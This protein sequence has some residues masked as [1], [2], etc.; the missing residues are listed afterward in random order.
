MRSMRVGPA[1]FIEQYK[2]YNAM[3]VLEADNSISWCAIIV[4][5]TNSF[6]FHFLS[7]VF[8]LS[9]ALFRFLLVA[10]CLFNVHV[11]FLLFSFFFLRSSCVRP[12]VFLY[13]EHAQSDFLQCFNEKDAFFEHLAVM[14]P[15]SA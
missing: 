9:S 3:P 14:F 4:Y 2:D 1:I 15:V 10:F 12:C 13:D 5:M 7:S 8:R 11:H 6:V